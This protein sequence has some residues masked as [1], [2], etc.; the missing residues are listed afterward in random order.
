MVFSPSATVYGDPASVPD[1]RGLPDHGDQSLRL[2]QL[3]GEQILRR[4]GF[5]PR[6]NVVLLRY[7]NPVGR[8]PAAVSAR[9]PDGLPNNL[10]PFVSQVAV[11][12]LPPCAFSATIT[13]AGRNRVRDYIHVVDPRSAIC[14]RSSASANCPA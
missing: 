5:G 4:C 2:D 7:F 12:R 9:I 13:D 11:G 8:T 10:M 3:M 14:A 6:W 1:P